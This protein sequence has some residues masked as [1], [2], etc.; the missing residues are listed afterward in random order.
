MSVSRKR[1][2]LDS[3]VGG[4]KD[5]PSHPPG[6]GTGEARIAV[7]GVHPVPEGV[8]HQRE[9]GCPILRVC[10]SLLRREEVVKDGLYS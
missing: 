4:E 9:A 3:C 2:S 6:A 8:Q 10:V 7:R 1:L 5:E